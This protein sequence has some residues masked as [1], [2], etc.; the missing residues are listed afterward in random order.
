MSNLAPEPDWLAIERRRDAARAAGRDVSGNVT[1]AKKSKSIFQSILDDAKQSPIATVLGAAGSALGTGLGFALGSQRAP[2][3]TG[4]VG[5]ETASRTGRFTEEQKESYTQRAEIAAPAGLGAAGPITVPLA[6]AEK[7]YSEA[8]AKPLSAGLLLTDPDSPLYEGGLIELPDGEGGTEL[9]QAPQDLPGRI[10]AARRR[11]EVVPFSRAYL[12]NPISNFGPDGVVK[13]LGGFESYNPWSDASM[14][15]A[16]ENAFYNFITGV[17]QIAPEAVFPLAVRPVRLAAQ[18]SLG[19]RTTIKDPQDLV[20]LRED[21]E[22]GR[23]VREN[24]RVAAEIDI[25]DGATEVPPVGKTTPY[26][27]DIEFLANEKRIDRIKT[28]PFVANAHGIDKTSFADIIRRTDDPDTVNELILASRGD[29]TALQNLYN[30][31]PDSVWQMADMNS[32]VRNAWIEGNP[33]RPKGAEL[34]RVNQIFDSP[35]ARDDYFSDVKRQFLDPDG[36]FRGG[37]TW[38]PTRH[39]LIE[40]IRG[41]AGA[42]R[43][44]VRSSDYSDAP[45][46][47]TKRVNTGYGR[48][49]TVFAQWASSRQPLGTVSLSGNR[50]DDWA[51]ELTAMMDSVPELRGNRPITV[52]RELI[53][54]EFV[55]TTVPAPVYRQAVLER[56]VEA[57][58][59]GRLLEVWRQ[60]E[61]DLIFT[62]SDTVGL[63]RSV[64]AEFLRGYRAAMQE[65]YGDITSNGGFFF[66]EMGDRVV[67]DPKTVSQ[68]LD[69]FP[70]TPLEEI[71]LAMKSE[72]SSAFSRVSGPGAGATSV[73]DAGLKFFRTNVLLR[74]GYTLKF[75]VTE[76]LIAMYLA[77]GS[78]LTDEGFRATFRNA[79]KNM[80]NRSKRVAYLANL[81]Q[82]I[83]RFV[84][85]QP[86]ASRGALRKDIENLVAERYNTKVA[87][88]D[89]L[90]ELDAMRSGKRSPA[91]V[92]AYQDEVRGELVEAQLRLN[93]IEDALDEKIPTWRQVV[94]P[95]SLSDVREK[96]FEYQALVGDNPEYLTNAKAQIEQIREVARARAKGKEPVYTPNEQA[97]LIKLEGVVARSS[98]QIKDV[99]GL[100][101]AIV[102]LQR[103]YDDVSDFF[104]RDPKNYRKAIDE[105]EKKIK[106]ID[107]KIGAKQVRLGERREKIAAVS[108]ITGYAGSGQGYTTILVGGEPIQIPAAFSTRAQD[109]GTALRA[110]SSTALTTRKTYDPSY[111]ASHETA[112]WRRTGDIEVIEPTDRVYWDELAWVGNNQMRND[113]LV[114][115]IL[116]DKT[117]AEIAEWLDSSAGRAYQ[118]TMGKSYL[119]RTESYSDPVRDLPETDPRSAGMQDI[120]LRPSDKSGK[121]K[122]KKLPEVDGPGPR[123]KGRLAK[124]A[125]KPRGMATKRVLLESTTELDEM[126]RI[127]N[128]YFPDSK[129]RQALAAGEMD[130]GKLQRM[131]GG[132]QDLSRIVGEDLQYLPGNR[133]SVVMNWYNRAL[134]NVW[135]W[136]ATDPEDRIARWPF[137]NREFIKQFELR[138]NILAQQG[139]RLDPGSKQLDSLRQASKRAA[140]IETEKVFYNIR[141][142]NNPV[143]MSRFLLSFPGAFFNSFYRYGRL[144]IKEPERTFQA[145]LFA[146]NILANGGVD[147]DGNP[148]KDIRDAKYI[149]IPGTRRSPTDTGVRV[150]I[151]SLATLIIG[152]PGF[153]YAVAFGLSVANRENPKVDEMARKIL[154]PAYEEMLP[155]GIARNPASTMFGGWQKDFWRAINGPSDFDFIQTSIYTYADSVALWEKN[156]KEG[157]S[158]SFEDA[159]NSSRAFYFARAGAKFVNAFSIQQQAPGQLMRNAWF[160]YR[161]QYGDDSQ[162]AREAF[163]KQYGDWA[164]WYTYS[165]SEYATFVPSTMEAYERIWE[166]HPDLSRELVSVSGDDLGMLN[167]LTLGASGEFSQSISNFLRDNPLPGDSQPVVKRMQPEKFD[168]M[169]RVSDGWNQYNKDKVIY[170]AEYNRLRTLRNEAP[171]ETMR[172]VYRS[173][174]KQLDDQWR[175]YVQGLEAENDAWAIDRAD[176]GGQRAKTA[177]IYL[178]KMF[179][180]EKFMNTT[181]K[182]PIYQ[183][184]KFFLEQRENALELVRNEKDSDVKKS[185][186]KQFIEFVA[187]DISQYNP[188][189]GAFF[190]RYF[191][192]EWEVE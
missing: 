156:G 69:G 192:S 158:P 19:L 11:A 109:F 84:K 138:A 113:P 80:K 191:L 48:P 59:Q 43:Y 64:T 49:A 155:Y 115:L 42:V 53:D 47:I 143:Y 123:G 189:F 103:I 188:D 136:I 87:L 142:Y 88:E 76:P 176:S 140:I 68:M 111:R 127:V 105:L 177:S 100:R 190:D 172:S 66:D 60:V 40:K 22:T 178:K 122:F 144:A 37:A 162:A 91:Q 50:P 3:S 17:V 120:E 46:W 116:Q 112:K 58:R 35:I 90:G 81:D 75:S 134:D 85:G 57:K 125:A 72:L 51:V 67:L 118:K 168:N 131:M 10:S 121:I 130:P 181:G 36:G 23:S 28:H 145:A 25:A 182:L 83:N 18:N 102:D 38:I 7:V 166:K 63:N 128:Q 152:P 56:L 93:A 101:N 44:A 99:E 135:R 132:R 14:E 171:D 41:K 74:P 20:L 2:L 29:T 97:Q 94:E 187:S 104:D 62:M 107:N 16:S 148:V 98:S 153:S 65:Q 4:I 96:I 12:A 163:M 147:E 174:I 114:N 15:D 61:D 32:A 9:V 160:K 21:Y 108:G 124:M 95:A 154:G 117:Y 110:E 157:P 26:Y 169:I 52:G 106:I 5:L 129:V 151:E 92:L 161:D 55:P 185:I 34:A 77:T 6:A 86:A 173:Q 183:D 89:K 150:P 24:Q 8:F 13:A 133:G 170:D 30:A 73:F 141:R 126:I 33:Y 139:V 179:A 167:L 27:D 54:G 175:E 149:L 180:N 184:I 159:I 119:R 70:T 164:R 146:E 31:A 79:G 186:K 71:V 82:V 165:S 78:V 1:R 137:M 39:A 45:A